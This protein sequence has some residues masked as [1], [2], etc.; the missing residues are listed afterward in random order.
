VLVLE[1][2]DDEAAPRAGLTRSAAR[3]RS[4]SGRAALGRSCVLARST[5][6]HTM[7]STSLV[8]SVNRVA[9]VDP[10]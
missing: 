3:G 4:G 1:K 8:L 9:V 2:S 6:R 10:V 7:R 5:T